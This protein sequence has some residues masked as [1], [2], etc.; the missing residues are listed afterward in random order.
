M[1]NKCRAFSESKIGRSDS[2]A[3]LRE[4]F[5]AGWDAALCKTTAGCSGACSKAAPQPVKRLT[6][7]EIQDMLKVGNPTEDEY[8]LIRMGWNSAH[9]ITKE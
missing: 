5:Y 6:D 2:N 3:T 9:G 7:E 8:R 4:A 1:S